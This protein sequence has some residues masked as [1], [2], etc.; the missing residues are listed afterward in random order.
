MHLDQLTAFDRVVREGSFSRAAVALSLGQPAVSARIRVLEEALGGALFTRGRRVTLTALGESFLPYA[1]RA[2]EV[3][4]EGVEAAR[5]AQTGRRGRVRLGALASLA[6]G[7][8]G[9]AVA[10][11]VRRH[12]QV[13]CT[14]R[15]GDHERILS[16]LLD[17][18]LE[19]GLLAWPAREAGGAELQAVLTFREPVLLVVG[20]GHPLAARRRVTREELVR[21]A[22]PLL[23]LRWWPAHHPALLALAERTGQA[24]EVAMEVARHL[25]TEGVGAGF[26]TRTFVAGA[27]ARGEL[28]ALEVTDL[29]PLFRDSALARRRRGPP[30]SPASSALVEALRRQALRQGLLA[31]RSGP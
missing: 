3:L 13:D 31:R 2:L 6:E 19:L 30:L 17:G 20:R 14:Q 26:F 11:F 28:C 8:V 24:T 5:L 10:D 29:G 12:P 16:L 7:L 9:P 25:V 27:L 15:S 22:R 21:Q 4:G 1:R 23:R 18:V